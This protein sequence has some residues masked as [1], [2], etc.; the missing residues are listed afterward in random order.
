MCA[1]RRRSECF[2]RH[3]PQGFSQRKRAKIFHSNFMQGKKLAAITVAVLLIAPM[4]VFARA[5][6]LDNTTVSGGGGSTAGSSGGIYTDPGGRGGGGGNLPQVVPPPV[7]K[8]G[9]RVVVIS[10]TGARVR[11]APIEYPV[12]PTPGGL[13]G[14]SGTGKFGMTAGMLLG[15]V[16]GVQ[17]NGA[18]GTVIEGPRSGVL[19]YKSNYTWWKVDFDTGVDGWV[20]AQLIQPVTP[21]PIQP[22][23]P[24]QPPV[25]PPTPANPVIKIGD[26]VVVI[27]ATGARVR[28]A[29]IEYVLPP[30]SSKAGMVQ[31]EPPGTIRGVQ[32]QGARGTVIGG[33]DNGSAYGGSQFTWWKVDFDTGVD[34]WVA[35]Q[36]I[37]P[38]SAS[39]TPT[40]PVLPNK[41]ASNPQTS[42]GSSRTGG[43]GRSGTI[44]GGVTPYTPIKP[45]G[46]TPLPTPA[47][48]TPVECQKIYDQLSSR[49]VRMLTLYDNLLQRDI[50]DAE[51]IRV[52][53]AS[54]RE[55]TMTSVTT[56]E[57]R[58][59]A[60]IDRLRTTVQTPEEEQLLNNLEA[61]VT[62]ALQNRRLAIQGSLDRAENTIVSMLDEKRLTLTNVIQEQRQFLEGSLRQF[63]EECSSL[64]NQAITNREK[65]RAAR[66]ISMSYRRQ[67][68][69]ITRSFS[70]R[71]REVM[72]SFSREYRSV[73][74]EASSE[75]RTAMRSREI[76]NMFREFF[77]Q[78]QQWRRS[79]RV[80]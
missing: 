59:A 80:R 56:Y 17:P 2:A 76:T 62:A 71:F 21:S 39:P 58:I 15:A 49:A 25:R 42:L 78:T 64:V 7:I 13:P 29:P 34:G 31:P 79:K 32:P 65:A 22:P 26:R 28:N 46:V 12:K 9:D 18:K 43:N 60:M 70:S 37:Q 66:Q 57:D 40:N 38:V 23:P 48:T 14:G 68:H 74:R 11:N 16:L 55:R 5:N 53:L 45:P 67:L 1:A 44:G 51:R 47:P 73:L 75:I 52:R 61:K 27:S 41:P 6:L 20:A 63:L 33:P 3:K 77:R 8:I 72:R 30:S 69:S 10:A 54:Y 19:Q 50:S 24:V 35:A 4:L 36:L